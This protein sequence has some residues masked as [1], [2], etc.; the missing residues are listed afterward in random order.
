LVGKSTLVAA[1]AL[2]P[3]LDPPELVGVVAGLVVPQPATNSIPVKRIA[4][5]FFITKFPS[6]KITS[7]EPL[8]K[9][10]SV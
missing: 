3:L 9:Y 8:P 1:G 4:K 10:L 6:F 5:S 2:V 7:K